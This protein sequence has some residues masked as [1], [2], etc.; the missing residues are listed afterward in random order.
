MRRILDRDD[1]SDFDEAA[2]ELGLAIGVFDP[3]LHAHMRS[4]KHVFWS[5]NPL[6]D[7]LHRTLLEL[8]SAGVLEHRDEPDLQFRWNRA[9]RVDP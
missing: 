7:A 9:F 5:A 6:G 8:A 2:Y 1:W 3:V 4:C